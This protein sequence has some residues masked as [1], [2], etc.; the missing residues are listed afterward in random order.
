MD[1]LLDVIGVLVALSAAAVLLALL[2]RPA[3]A[4]KHLADALRTD[5]SD[6]T[7]LTHLQLVVGKTDKNLCLRRES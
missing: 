7:A 5:V 4:A 6:E 2:F 3:P 1:G